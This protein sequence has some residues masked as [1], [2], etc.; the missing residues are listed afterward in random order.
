MNVVPVISCASQANSV[1]LPRGYRLL[2]QHRLAVS[3]E[4]TQASAVRIAFALGSYIVGASSSQNVAVTTSA[5]R[6]GRT[7]G[8]CWRPYAGGHRRGWASARRRGPGVKRSASP[9]G[10]TVVL[11]PS[12]RSD[13]GLHRG[14]YCAR[15]VAVHPDGC[16]SDWRRHR[17]THRVA[18]GGPQHRASSVWWCIGQGYHW[19]VGAVVIVGTAAFAVSFI[20]LR[21]LMVRV[22]YSPRIA[23]LFPVI[24]DCMVGVATVALVALGDKPARRTRTATAPA[25]AQVK[26]SAPATP[27]SVSSPPRPY[28]VRAD[29]GRIKCEIRT[30]GFRT[31]G[32]IRTKSACGCGGGLRRT[33]T[34]SGG[35]GCDHEARGSGRVDPPRKCAAGTAPNRIASD[36]GIHHKTVSKII[37]AAEDQRRHLVA[38]WPSRCPEQRARP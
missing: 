19:A 3:V 21:D 13:V 11:V 4:H 27:A 25:S 14:Q 22:G 26:A 18:G 9:L 30:C 6:A 29:Q 20:A 35:R 15:T 2:A 23:G 5:P 7:G 38:V 34:G 16:H 1:L 32:R 28:S 33:R 8:T 12:D 31:A 24:I 37:G 10:H 17:A 36:M